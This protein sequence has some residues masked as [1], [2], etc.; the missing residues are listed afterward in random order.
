MKDHWKEWLDN[1]I[2]L[3]STPTGAAVGVAGFMAGVLLGN[4]ILSIVRG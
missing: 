4:I 2:Y 3:L 1:K